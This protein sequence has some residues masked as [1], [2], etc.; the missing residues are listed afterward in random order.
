MDLET[1]GLKFASL[2]LALLCSALGGACGGS[3]SSGGSDG[4]GFTGNGSCALSTSG[5]GGNVTS[6]DD[7]GQGFTDSLA[8][9][10]CSSQMGTFSTSACPATGR[11]G[12]CQ[13]TSSNGAD[14]DQVS[15][16]PPT[17]AADVMAACSMENGMDGVS[18]TFVPN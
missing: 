1:S 17:T 2:W 15:F 16:Y 9:Q 4:E 14:R 13:I 7:F 8:T 6:C 11:V 5:S 3:T 12:R 10:A 18:A